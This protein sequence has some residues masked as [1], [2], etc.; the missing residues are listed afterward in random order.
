MNRCESSLRIF[1][2]SS[3]CD[4]LAVRIFWGVG[5]RSRMQTHSLLLLLR[6]ARRAGADS[7]RKLSARRDRSKTRAHVHPLRRDASTL[8]P[9]CDAAGV[10]QTSFRVHALTDYKTREDSREARSREFTMASE[11]QS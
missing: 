3:S 9:R 10:E 1:L 5:A 2:F 8:Q 11:L 6:L 7:Y 4:S